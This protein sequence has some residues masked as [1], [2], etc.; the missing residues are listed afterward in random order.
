VHLKDYEGGNFLP[1][2]QGELDF[3]RIMRALSSIQYD[4][5]ITV[6]LDT[7]EGS[8]KEAAQISRRFLSEVTA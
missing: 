3:P 1:L 4:G 6:E 5:W 7:Y 8:P 2:G